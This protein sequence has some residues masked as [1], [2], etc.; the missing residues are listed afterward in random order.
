MLYIGTS[1]YSY[2]D[3][4]GPFYP[5]GTKQGEMLGFYSGAFD[6]T[7]INSTYYA[8]PNSHMM[9]NM[10]KKTAAGFVF[11]VK[12]HQSMTHQRNAGE[13][14][15]RQFADAVG[16]LRQEGKLGCLV[17][18]FPYSF[19]CNRENWTYILS[20][21]AQFPE[22][23]LVVEFR[24]ARWLRE[25]VFD[26]L[27]KNGLGYV[28]VDEPAIA[29]LLDRRSVHTSKTAY[30]RFH[31]RNQEKWYNHKE[32]YERYDYLYK[33]PELEEWADKVK[34]LAQETENCFVSFNNHFRAQAV[35]NGLML[36]RML[37]L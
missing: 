3:W 37:G 21:K 24:N 7:E 15:Y 33:E 14:E 6:F 35:M 34:G 17:A 9:Y 11:T 30:I 1:G 22:D 16:I 4:I 20:V 31:G 2:Q 13:K 25:E 36:K 27:K 32:A 18:Q 12:L 29:G 8:I 5:E 28:C 19:H 23:E 26:L 10:Q